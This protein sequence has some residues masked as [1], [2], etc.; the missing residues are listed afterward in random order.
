M[1]SLATNTWKPSST[2]II[3]D[4]K[5]NVVENE[6]TSSYSLRKVFENIYEAKTW[7]DFG[8]GSG[9]GSELSYMRETVDKILLNKAFVKY[10]ITNL[11]DA[12]C[13]MFHFIF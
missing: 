10:E 7:G 2:I 11:I 9:F 8:Q 3:Q 12:S 4:A 1:F 5:S 6:S 13:G